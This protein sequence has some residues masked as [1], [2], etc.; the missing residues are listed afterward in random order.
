MQPD[1]K[2]EEGEGNMSK[3][4]EYQLAV[5]ACGQCAGLL[6]AHDVRGLIKAISRAETVGPMLDPT[7][8]IRNRDKML[9]DKELLEAALPL[10]RWYEKVKRM[11]EEGAFEV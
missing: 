4:E 11:Q 8:Y 7:A 1:C 2:D 10:I 9:Q 3:E 6:A 5:I